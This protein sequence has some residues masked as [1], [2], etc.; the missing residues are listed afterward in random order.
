VI[1]YSY[2][3]YVGHE[4]KN[5][6]AVLSQAEPRYAAVNFDRPTYRILQ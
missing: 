6:K 1:G 4:E 5:K 2:E 3:V